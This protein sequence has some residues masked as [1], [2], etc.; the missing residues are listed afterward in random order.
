MAYYY[1]FSIFFFLPHVYGIEHY[2][3]L[4]TA[5]YVALNRFQYEEPITVYNSIC[6][7]IYSTVYCTAFIAKNM[8]QGGYFSLGQNLVPLA[9]QAPVYSIGY[10]GVYNTIYRAL[11]RTLY[12]T[13]YSIL[14]STVNS[15]V[16]TTETII[17]CGTFQKRQGGQFFLE[18]Q[19]N[20]FAVFIQLDLQNSVQYSIQYSIQ[21]VVQYSLQ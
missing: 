5:L 13:M 2:T 6:T 20:H 7:T 3:V 12:C 11:Y 19:A 15:K 4:H 9:T 18:E 8:R 14:H 10:S 1:F 17:V 16:Y 21:H